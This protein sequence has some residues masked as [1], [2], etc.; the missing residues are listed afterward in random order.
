M[1]GHY[2]DPKHG[3]CLRKI[4]KISDGEYKIIGAY[5]DDE[6]DTGKK[7]TASVLATKK[8]N[9]Y[10]VDFTGKAHVKHGHYM[11]KWIPSKRRIKWEDGNVW[12]LMYDWT[13]KT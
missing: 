13:T 5:G 2:F 10:Y 4:K 1:E 11:M 6:P 12:V 7:W 3:G 8:T 9:L